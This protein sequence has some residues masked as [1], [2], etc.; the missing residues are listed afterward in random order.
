LGTTTADANLTIAGGQITAQRALLCNAGTIT[1]NG[2]KFNTPMNVSGTA[3]GTIN[4]FGGYYVSDG[5]LADYCV[6]PYEVRPTTDEDKA[7][8]GEMYEFKVTD[9][10]SSYGLPLDIIDYQPNAVT[11]NM[12]GYTSDEEPPLGWEMQAYGAVYHLEDCAANRTV[13]VTLPESAEAGANIRI[14]VRSQAGTVESGRLYTMPHI[15]ESNAT[16]PEGDYSSSTLY[17]RSGTLTIDQDVTVGK[18]IVCAGAAVE[19]TDG[20]LTTDTLVLRGTP[21]E[22]ATVSGSIEAAKTF[23]TRIG[24]D[25]S[26]K[27]PA[28]RYYPIA[29]PTGYCSPLVGV[30]L[31]N[32]TTP[33]YGVSWGVKKRG[34]EEDVLLTIDDV[35]DTGVEYELFSSR[36]YYREYYFPLAPSTTDIPMLTDPNGKARKVLVDGRLLIVT[37]DGV[38]DAMGRSVVS[39]Q[40]SAISHQP[41]AISIQ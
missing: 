17:V 13:R 24:P 1:V 23:F 15:F 36:N 16:L 40:P 39:R 6:F 20:L 3:A 32:G 29:L 37:G 9:E 30:R 27:Y 8:V 26:E 5:Q 33:A 14:T 7:R 12:N 41:S 25:G 35:L 18:V 21:W 19:V 34:G 38:Y 2:G 28:S 4:L 11:V 31:S 22:T 10:Y